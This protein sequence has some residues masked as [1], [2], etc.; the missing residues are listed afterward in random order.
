MINTS[1]TVTAHTGAMRTK[2]NSAASIGASIK[3]GADITEMDVT[4]R[5]D[6]T[7]VII[8]SASPANG[9]GLP[10][11]KALEAVSKSGTLRMNLDLKAF[12]NTAAVQKALQDA[13]L[14]ERAF[15]T[16]VFES[17]VQEVRSGSPLV[18]YYI[19]ASI[20]PDERENGEALN[21]L[22]E[23][24]TALGGI[25]LNTHYPN[26]NQKVV[27]VMHAHSLLVSAWTVRLKKDMERLIAMGVD[28]ITTKN[29]KKLTTILL[30][31]KSGI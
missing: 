19:N 9:E 12:W 24:I 22:A 2:A 28:N 5:S 14:L 16:G 15:Y 13:G 3:Y 25:G 20:S 27:D 11:T 17:N 31:F 30:P 21:A 26:L 18:P 29:P 4:F 7:P 8:H 6:G 23:R 1:F 10:F